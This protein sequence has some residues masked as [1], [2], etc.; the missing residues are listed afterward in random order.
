HEEEALEDRGRRALEGV[1]L[2]DVEELAAH[3]EA[4]VQRARLG[5][6]ARREARLEVLQ[7]DRV[8]LRHAFRGLVVALHHRFARAPR[9]R[10]LEAELGGEGALQVEHQP[11]L[12]PAGEVVQADAQ[13]LQMRLEPGELPRLVALD[14]P[15]ADEVA[16]ARAQIRIDARGARD[17]LDRLQVAQ[18]ARR[19]LQVRLERVGR[20]LVLGV[21]LLLLELLRL[22]ERH[23][24]GRRIER[25]PEAA[26]ELLASHEETRFE[27]RGAAGVVAGRALDAPLDGD[28]TIGTTLLE[29]RFLVGSKE[30]FRRLGKALDSASDPVSFF[31]AKKLEQEQRH[32]KHQDSPYSLEP[33][34]KEA[35][36]GLRDLQTIQWIARA[37]GIN[38]DLGTSWS[39]LVSHGLIQRDEARQLARLEA[40][41]QDLRIRL[42]YLAGRREDRLVFDLQSALAAQLGFKD[43]PARRA[44]EAMMQRYYQTAKGVT[45]L[46]TILL[47]N[48]EARL[49][50]R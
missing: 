39:D 33:N 23:R 19:F 38:S 27:E 36:G 10:V 41:L 14:E 47:Q 20:V 24:I 42:H 22:E 13:V 11:V 21:A 43:T 44:S 28:I 49:A 26:E 8:E 50:P 2:L 45:Q 32:A 35:P 4:L 1:L 17:P 7:Q 9:R 30:L 48:L 34:L 25:F 37:A 3:L 31:K 6:R 16:P 46:N 15:V 29:S 18:A 40:H 12:A 5:V